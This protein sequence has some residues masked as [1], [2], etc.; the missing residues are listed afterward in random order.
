MAA[1]APDG[2]AIVYSDTVGRANQLWIKERGELKP[3]V[4]APQWEGPPYP[5]F[6]SD[7]QWVAF[8]GARGKLVRVSRR[9][10][11]PSVLSDSGGGSTAWLDDGTIVF[12]GS[13][14][15][16]IY[17]MSPGGGPARLEYRTSAT[18]LKLTAVPGTRAVIATALAGNAGAFTFD[19]AT[20]SVHALPQE[21]TAAW[22]VRGTL[23]Y[24]TGAGQLFAAAFDTRTF[25][26]RGTPTPVLQG[27]RTIAGLPDAALGRDG[28]LLYGEGRSS[29]A[30]WPASIALVRRDGA[31]ASTWSA[32][33]S[34]QGQR[35]DAFARWQ[36]RRAQ[37]RG[38]HQWPQRCVR[39][40]ARQQGH[41][42]ADLRGNP[43]LR[44]VLVARR[45]DHCVPLGRR[46]IDCHL[47]QTRRR[48][49]SG[50]QGE[51]RRFASGL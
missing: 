23:I 50:S 32:T 45:L 25:G 44:T 35:P 41:D 19:L 9:G 11:A 12:V 4:L 46:P 29:L 43:E 13:G 49:W 1:I 37:C 2:S 15:E 30:G 33:V 36:P 16:S 34:S 3:R 22:I 26:I 8:M 48:E 31:I 28:T 5:S 7:G 21:A 39:H 20:D 40:D 47:E 27:V 38:Q 6:S 51:A 17:S 10:G 42:A 14:G 24:A 18:I